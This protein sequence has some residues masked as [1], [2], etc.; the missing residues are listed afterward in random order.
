MVDR[1]CE[2][3]IVTDTQLAAAERHKAFRERIAAN[4]VPDTPIACRYVRGAKGYRPAVKVDL[5]VEV[6]APP[7]AVLHKKLRNKPKLALHQ[8]VPDYVPSKTSTTSLPIFIR[9]SSMSVE[10]IQRVVAA[11][12][13]VEVFDLA[14]SRRSIYLH[15]RCVAMFLAKQLTWES[16]QAIGL[17]FSRC[18]FTVLDCSRSI[19]KAAETNEKL[20]S[21]IRKIHWLLIEKSDSELL[22]LFVGAYSPSSSFSK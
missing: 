21:N 3:Q 1:V 12:Y 8:V 16:P 10:R 9:R 11:Y 14:H 2:Q 4:A 7:S 22:E 17:Y 6:G 15:A 19:R 18:A 5:P 13:R 20:V